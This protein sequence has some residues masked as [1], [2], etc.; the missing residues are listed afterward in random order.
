[1]R[2][3][4]VLHCIE[5]TSMACDPGLLQRKQMKYLSKQAPSKVTSFQVC[6]VVRELQGGRSWVQDICRQGLWS[7]TAAT[8]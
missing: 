8:G 6:I 5:V 3:S 2:F 1:M 4:F 7:Q